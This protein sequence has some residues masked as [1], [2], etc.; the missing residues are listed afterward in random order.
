MWRALDL[1]E[2]MPADVCPY[3][4]LLSG[5]EAHL[6]LWNGNKLVASLAVTEALVEEEWEEVFDAELSSTSKLYKRGGPNLGKVGLKTLWPLDETLV[7]ENSAQ[8]GVSGKQDR[9]VSK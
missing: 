3:L 4:S 1:N 2:E 5:E 7:T 8:D 9:R 6:Q